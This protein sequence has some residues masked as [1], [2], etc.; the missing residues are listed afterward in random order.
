MTLASSHRSVSKAAHSSAA[1]AAA[2]FE[3]ESSRLV[4][5]VT[6][7]GGGSNCFTPDVLAGWIEAKGEEFGSVYLVPTGGSNWMP[8]YASRA[9]TGTIST[10]HQ[11]SLDQQLQGQSGLN[12]AYRYSFAVS[13][14]A[15]KQQRFMTLR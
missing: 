11:M 15:Q 5:Y 4:Q 1:G 8:D 14:E 12:E 7:L 2:W 3:A 10:I 6:K 9:R 13:D